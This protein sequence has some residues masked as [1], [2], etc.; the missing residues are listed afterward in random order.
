MD[1]LMRW[2]VSRNHNIGKNIP[3]RGSDPL[4]LFVDIFPALPAG[5]FDR[6][7]HI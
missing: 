4:F 2:R 1:I 3:K 7:S 6:K 5:R